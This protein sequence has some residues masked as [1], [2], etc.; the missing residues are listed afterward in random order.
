MTVI[1]LI[2]RLNKFP[3]DAIVKEDCN[4]CAVREVYAETE[5]GESTV[6]YLGCD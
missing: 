2:D 6:V 3:A 5:D 1:E 4:H